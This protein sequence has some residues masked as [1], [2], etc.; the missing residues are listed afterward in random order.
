MEFT[1][2]LATLVILLLPALIPVLLMLGLLATTLPLPSTKLRPVLLIT[3][4]PAL[5]LFT[6]KSFASLTVNL[7][8][9]SATTPILLSESFELSVT[10]PT[11]FN[12]SPSLRSTLV[13][14]SAWK[15]KVVF[16]KSSIAELVRYN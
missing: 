13:P 9:P 7:L 3:V 10:P 4:P 15:V 12:V 5:T 16:A 6:A 8:F 2:P 11:I 1:S 14:E